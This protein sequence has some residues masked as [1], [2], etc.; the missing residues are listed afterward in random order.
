MNN[1]TLGYIQNRRDDNGVDPNRDFGYSRS[2]N[3]CLKSTTGQLFHHIMSENLIQTAVTFH[4]G[5][6]AIGYEW[7]SK[8][9]MKPNDKSPDDIAN[10]DI[11]NQMSA[12]AGSFTGEKNYPGRYEYVVSE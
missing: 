11:A 12:F 1:N 7:G 9:H 6:V 2:D 3:N 10:V 8:N 4:G 5:M